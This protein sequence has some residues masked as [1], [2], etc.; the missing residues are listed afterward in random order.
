MEQ[1]ESLDEREKTLFESLIYTLN[2]TAMQQLC[3]TNDPLMQNKDV[4]LLGATDT[5]DL[6]IALKGKTEG[7]LSDEESRFLDK[8]IANVSNH[9]LDTNL[10]ASL[11]SPIE[12]LEE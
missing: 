2:L 10:K 4:D 1:E 8:I 5:Y 9:L 3:I 12:I 7:S 6:L 11:I